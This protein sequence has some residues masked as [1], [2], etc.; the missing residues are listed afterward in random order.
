MKRRQVLQGVQISNF[1]GNC[2]QGFHYVSTTVIFHNFNFLSIQLGL[3][4]ILLAVNSQLQFPQRHYAKCRVPV[5]QVNP[6]NILQTIV[7]YI[8][9]YLQALVH[10]KQIYFLKTYK[11]IG[12]REPGGLISH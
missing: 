6:L 9:H 10:W 11:L 8:Y 3:R 5:F 7:S 1:W 2:T 4:T 12:V